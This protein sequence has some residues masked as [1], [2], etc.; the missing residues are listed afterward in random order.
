MT[1][2]IQARA[3]RAATVVVSAGP[4]EARGLSV[5]SVLPLIPRELQ[6]PIGASYQ[7]STQTFSG[8]NP[9]YS[10]TVANVGATPEWKPNDRLTLRGIFDWT[11]TS[12]AKTLPIILTGGDYQPPQTPRGYYGQDWAEGRSLAENYGGILTARLTQ[13]WSLAAGLFRSVADNPVSYTDLYLDTQPD[14]SAEHFVVGYPEQRTAS[15][16]GEARLTGHFGAGTWRQ[17]I[18]LLARGRDT[19]AFYGGS[20]LVDLGPALIDQGIQVPEP[21]FTYSARTH[22]H[23]E[24]WS[25]GIAYR[26]QWRGRGDFAFGLQQESYSKDVTFPDIPEAHL[27]DHPLRAY[28]IFALALT[29]RATAYAGYTQG[30]EDSGVAASS[31]VN[32]GAILPDAR[33]WQTDAGIRYLLSPRV[34]LIAGVFEIEKPYFNLDPSSVDRELGTQRATGLE[35]SLSG[36]VSTNLNV[37]AAMLWGEVKVEGANLAAQ[38][39]GSMALNQARFTSTVNASYRFPRLPALSA[40]ISILRF[41]SY[42]ASID[43][44]AQASPATVIAL[45]GR[46]RFTALGAPATLRVQVQNLTN[47]YFWNLGLNSPTFSQYQPRALFGYLT[48]DF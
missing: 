7:T 28:G 18:V 23:T 31:A 36:E 37:T 43:D 3:R 17:D 25:A 20:D 26:A 5:D 44:V 32:R 13:D 35:L 29:D 21:S 11:Q 30:L 47:V 12:D 1:C 9:G 15:T 40:D 2:D 34:K 24:L 45:G 8:P 33:T 10:S 42:P 48:A 46:Y 6:L 22:D 27:A 38:G 4:F 16:S 14:G 41:G 39:I 19:L